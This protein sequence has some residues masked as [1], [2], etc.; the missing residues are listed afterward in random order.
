M[1]PIVLQTVCHKANNEGRVRQSPQSLPLRTPQLAVQ[2]YIVFFG[3][4][5]YALSARYA[6]SVQDRADFLRK[7]VEIRARSGDVRGCGYF[8][9]T[10][11]AEIRSLRKSS[12]LF[13]ACWVIFGHVIAILVVRAILWA[14][15]PAMEFFSH[16]T[17]DAYMVYGYSA[18]RLFSV[19][20]FWMVAAFLVSTFV[21]AVK[22]LFF[23]RG[24]Q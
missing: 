4:K 1:R 8:V 19:A 2:L 18:D 20:E 9:N 17:T 16:E 22:Q 14:A 24:H 11:R 7:I 6:P 13:R 10:F 21:E 12:P 5:K 23:Y 3:V 15:H